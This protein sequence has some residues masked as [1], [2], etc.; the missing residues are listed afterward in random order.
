MNNSFKIND[1]RG[2]G[3]DETF[4]YGDTINRADRQDLR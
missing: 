1:E 3:G 2:L 4:F